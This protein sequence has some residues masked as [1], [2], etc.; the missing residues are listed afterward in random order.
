MTDLARPETRRCSMSAYMDGPWRCG[1]GSCDKGPGCEA[2][3][4]NEAEAR[5]VVARNEALAW[6]NDWREALGL[7]V[8]TYTLR[9]A[10]SEIR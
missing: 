4:R 9:D 3:R 7:P 5:R 6:E 10:R 8:K 1:S 2:P